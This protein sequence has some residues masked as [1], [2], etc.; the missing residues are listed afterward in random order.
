M[1]AIAKFSAERGRGHRRSGQRTSLPA[2]RPNPGASFMTRPRRRLTLR[3]KLIFAAVTVIGFFLSLELLLV[4][5]GVRPWYVLHDPYVGFQPGLPLFVRDGDRWHT[6]P[7]KLAFFNDQSFPVQKGP[8]TYRVFCL[9]GSTTFGHPYDHRTSFSGWLNARL[10]DANPDR[11]WEAINCGGIS[12]ASYRVCLLM[13]ELCQYEPDLFIV[14]TGHNE[15]LEQR[16]YGGTQAKDGWLPRIG[17]WV[18]RTRTATLLGSAVRREEAARER[19]LLSGEVDTILDRSVGPSEYHRDEQRRANVVRHFRLGLQR[20]CGLARGCGARVIFVSP[21]SNMRDFSP[22]KSEH[23]QSGA[24]HERECERLLAE[25]RAAQ[26]AGDVPAAVA[27]YEKAVQFD[28]V[29]AQAAW[30][31]GRALLA[32]GRVPAARSTLAR[33][34]DEDVCPL[35]A[36]SAIRDVVRD[37]T[38]QENVPLIDFPRILADQRP[39]GTAEGLLGDE[40]FLDHVHPTIEGHRL[41]A[42]ALFDQLVA[43]GIAPQRPSDEALVKRLSTQV[44]ADIDSRAQALALVQV[45][46]V[47]SWAGKNEEALNLTERAEQVHPGLSDV[48]SYRGRLLEK[49]GRDEEAMACFEEAI[50]RN[51]TDSLALSRAGW[52]AIRREKYVDA[53]AYFATALLHT[54]PQAPAA[55]QISTHFGLGVAFYHLRQWREAQ[56]EIRETLRLFPEHEGARELLDEV[57]QQLAAPG[58]RGS[59]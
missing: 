28:P 38:R 3:K 10:R 2:D 56:I 35:R 5:V 39:D 47:L 12:Y 22:F 48:P 49:L 13:Q 42:W 8:R 44:L 25:A 30:E 57:Q 9:G 20:M 43:W 18:A 59:G 21:A 33:A 31:A 16:T 32:A 36:I 6:N 19:T 23:G 58:S 55:F 54:P 52:C 50:R 45:I 37:V 14:Y 26:A 7:A 15:F 4:A 40:S 46:Q 29:Y 24:R 41:L 34:V 27:G 1:R 11:D 17:A 53:R 51:P